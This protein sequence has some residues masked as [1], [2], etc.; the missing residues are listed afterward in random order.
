MTERRARYRTNNLPPADEFE[1][2]IQIAGL[3]KPVAEYRFHQPERGQRQ[4]QWRFDYAW[5]KFRVAVEIE[6][7]TWIGGRHVSGP[8]YA[9]DCEKYNQAAL[10]GWFVFRFTTDMVSSGLALQTIIKAI[11]LYS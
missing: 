11:A 10:Q 3:P 8:G 5:V 6:G 7:G 4:R 1:Q 9:K 2:Q